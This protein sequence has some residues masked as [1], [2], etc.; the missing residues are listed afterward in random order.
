MVETVQPQP[1]TAA[2]ALLRDL[3]RSAVAAASPEAL[4]PES[5]PPPGDGRLVVIAAGKAA[6]EMMRVAQAR[7]L[8]PLSGLVITRHGHLPPGYAPGPGVELVEAGHPTPDAN[9]LAAGRK[10]LD[11]ARSLGADDHLLLLLSGG[12]SSLLAAPAAGLT[13]A[14]K[15]AVTRALLRSG[16]AIDAVNIVRKHLSMIKGGRLAA[17]AG[18]AQVTTWLISDVPGDDPALVAS[19]P[20]VADRSTL[21]DARRIVARHGIDPPPAVAAALRDPRNES[22]PAEAPGLAGAQVRILGSGRDALDAAARLAAARGYKVDDLGDALTGEARVL[23]AEHAALARAAA[24]GPPRLI[25]SGGE[26]NVTVVNPDGRGGR[27]LEYLL[28][29]ALALDGAPGIS[30]IACDTD[31]IDGTEDAAGAMVFPDTLARARAGGLDPAGLLARNH[32]Y[33]LFEALGDLVFTGPTLT[34]VNDF[35]AILVEGRV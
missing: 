1:A 28:G 27:N 23:G 5:M 14:D 19:G 2:R 35:R 18:P 21:A 20:A 11:L 12:G 7:S 31:G 33:R 17:A 25:L 32:A 4:M 13:L 6:A 3:F 26:T 10:A 15:Q 34:N 30:A 29:L 16:A 8:S 22:P 9:S 24:G